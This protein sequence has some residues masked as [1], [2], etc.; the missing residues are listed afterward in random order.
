MLSSDRN[1]YVLQFFFSISCFF[2]MYTGRS[3]AGIA[4]FN[5][6]RTYTW[7][8][9]R[10]FSVTG[11]KVWNNLPAT[12]RKLNRGSKIADFELIFTRSASAIT[13]IYKC[14]VKT[15]RKSTTCFPV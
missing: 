9:G 4:M 15:N 5:V 1:I 8:G 13:P 6:L 7:L 3:S 10:S 11:L 14:S 2:Y 12:L